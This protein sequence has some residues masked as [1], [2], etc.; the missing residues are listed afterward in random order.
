LIRSRLTGTAV[1]KPSLPRSVSAIP[2]TLATILPILATLP[3][4][5]ILVTASVPGAN[6]Q[7]HRR[8]VGVTAKTMLAARRTT[9][10]MVMM[11]TMKTKSR[12]IFSPT[13][14]SLAAVIFLEFLQLSKARFLV[15]WK[16]MSLTLR[17]P[18]KGNTT[19]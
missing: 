16:D 13:A 3:A 6:Q 10:E 7:L 19:L 2:L 9:V 14:Q 4:F 17:P 11:K 12:V 18:P 1:I 15:D 5:A 8:Q